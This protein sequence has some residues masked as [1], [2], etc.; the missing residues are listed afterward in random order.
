MSKVTRTEHSGA[1]HGKGGFWGRKKDAKILSNKKRRADRKFHERE[2][3]EYEQEI[4][5]VEF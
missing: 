4:E 3:I 1:K 5:D 2:D